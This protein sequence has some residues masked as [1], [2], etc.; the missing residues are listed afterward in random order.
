MALAPNVEE[1]LKDAE[2]SL[3]AALSF[4]ARSEK[5]Y[6]SVMISEM[7]SKI[8]TVIHFDK[9]SDAIEEKMKNNNGKNPFSGMF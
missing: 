8:E 3:R 7:I 5:S 4:A 1:N 6:V 9:F 2:A